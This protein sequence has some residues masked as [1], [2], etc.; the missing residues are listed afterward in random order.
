MKSLTL[1]GA[2][3]GPN[4]QVRSLLMTSLGDLVAA[5]RVL[6]LI[7]D[8]TRT[9]PLELL[10]P[11]M[12]ESMHR[13]RHVDFMI[14]LGTH[15]PLSHEHI[16]SLLG[17]TA[18]ERETVYKHIGLHNHAWDDPAALTEVGVLSQDQIRAMA[19]RYWHPSLGGDVAIRLNRAAVEVDRIVILGPVFPHEVAG[20]S[21]GAKYLFPGISGPE[22]IDVSHWL[23][24]LVGIIDTIG[25][26][27][28]PVRSMIE[29]AADLVPTPITLAALVVD[30][31]GGIE[32]M[33]VGDRHEAWS[34]AVALSGKTHIQWLDQPLD[35][36]ISWA[37][38]MY[39]ELWTAGKAMYKL[40]P[41]LADGAEIII[42]AP[43]LD[44]VSRVHGR[45]IYEVG[46]HVLPYFLDQWEH[47]ADIPLA[48]LAHSTHVKGAGTFRHGIERAMVD[49]KLATRISPG[50][51]ARLNLGYVDPAT[52]D[53]VCPPA[54]WVVI[55]KAGEVLFR[56]RR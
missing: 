36:V 2:G 6:V 23:G 5:E 10:F 4:D 13:A 37:P 18:T 43:H 26:S 25:I 40:E 46:Y 31:E 29:A 20:F 48:V 11:L 44:T 24:A 53:P 41:A 9:M 15:P 14:A 8:H 1:Q 47:F 38:D 42:Y 34:E 19:G 51:C 39:D 45:Y 21:G 54:G 12:V 7:P 56:V 52:V 49:L 3:H 33:F 32:G 55:P 28:T 50:D 17:I 35:R 16:L 22:F 27:N 30:G